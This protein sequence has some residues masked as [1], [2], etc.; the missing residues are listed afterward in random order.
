MSA[1]RYKMTTGHLSPGIQQGEDSRGQ[2]EA[3]YV[4]GTD[5]RAA[6]SQ[7]GRK[8]NHHVYADR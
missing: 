8:D 4:R 5:N 7:W 1:E 2:H 3:E 6:R